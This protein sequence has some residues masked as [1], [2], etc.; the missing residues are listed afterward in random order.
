M[1]SSRTHFSAARSGWLA[2]L[3]GEAHRETAGPRV[4]DGMQSSE[5]VQSAP[6]GETLRW[7]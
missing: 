4:L 6:E 1:A 5:G 2:A 3:S 7:A